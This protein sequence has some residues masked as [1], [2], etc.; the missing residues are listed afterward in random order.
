LS[1]TRAKV[2]IETTIVSYLRA[3][4]GSDLIIAAHQQLTR[5]WWR[6]RR[7]DFD[8]FISQAVIEEASAGDP[9]AAADRLQVLAQIRVLGLN[10]SALQLARALVSKG[11]L[12]EKAAVDALHIALATVHGMDYLLTWNC[13]HIANAETHSCALPFAR[14]RTAG[15]LHARGTYG[16]LALCGEIP[17]LMKQG[18]HGTNT[19]PGS[20]M[21]W[22]RFTVI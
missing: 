15:H 21:I 13:K 11:P 7:A 16:R 19:P 10:E 12:P 4:P 14:I 17:S 5:D 1:S 3:R 20:T 9:Q 22:R 8:L 18:R 2:Y 6:N